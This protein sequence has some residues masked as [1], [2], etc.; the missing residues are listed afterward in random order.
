[1]NGNGYIKFILTLLTVII[2]AAAY[3]LIESV[4]RVRD[5]N[6]RVIE[7]LDRLHELLASGAPASRPAGGAGRSRRFPVLLRIRRFSIPP[8]SPAGV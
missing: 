4:D 3:L 8:P 5:S 1:M 6:R 7:K 2:A